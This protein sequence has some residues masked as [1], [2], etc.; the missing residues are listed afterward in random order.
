MNCEEK[1]SNCEEINSDPD[2]I[3]NDSD[4]GKSKL[5]LKNSKRIK[6]RIIKVDNCVI[7]DTTRCDYVVE[8][9]I[10]NIKVVLFVELKGKNVEHGIEQLEK[11][12]NHM[13]FKNRYGSDLQKRAY[14]VGTKVNIPKTGWDNSRN[15][16]R[17]KYNCLLIIREYVEEDIEKMLGQLSNK[18]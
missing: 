3:I 17:K 14:V 11:T 5:R 15:K 6:V 7:E 12:I 2:I 16:F 13:C 9:P 4:G 8:I 1:I 18:D 10:D